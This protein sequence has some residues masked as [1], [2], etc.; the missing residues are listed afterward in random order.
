MSI[1]NDFM[2]IDFDSAADVDIGNLDDDL[3]IMG[4]YDPLAG[5]TTA[6]ST[7]ETIIKLE[8]QVKRLQIDLTKNLKSFLQ[9]IF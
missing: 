9:I 4:D 1:A 7:T 8:N 3:D 5:F 2:N 6:A